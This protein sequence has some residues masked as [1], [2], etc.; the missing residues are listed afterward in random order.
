MVAFSASREGR[1]GSPARRR[2]KTAFSLLAG[3]DPGRYAA[4]LGLYS[5][6]EFFHAGGGRLGEGFC[7]AL[8]GGAVALEQKRLALGYV[9]VPAVSLGGSWG[10]SASSGAGDASNFGPA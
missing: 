9:G 8:Y 4:N 1:L 7:A 6:G 2:P 5:G 10:D 3:G